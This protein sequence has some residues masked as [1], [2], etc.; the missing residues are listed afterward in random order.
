MK[1]LFGSLAMSATLASN[2]LAHAASKDEAAIKTIV[3]S[4]AVL[5]DRHEF[6]AL[7]T[8]YA[9]ELVLDYSSLSGAPAELKSPQALM[10]EW[11]GVLPGFDRTR[12]ALSDVDATIDGDQAAAIAYVEAGHWIND[13]YWQVD[14][15]YDYELERQAGAWKITSMTFTLETEIGSRDVFGPAMEAAAANPAPYIQRH[16]TRQAVIDFLSGL[17]DKDMETVNG[18][19][20]ED[21]VQ[22]MPYVPNGW[23]HQIIGKQGLIAQYAGWPDVSGA[24]NFTDELIFYPMVDPQTVYVEFKG[25]VDIVSTGRNYRQTYGALF[26][27]DK[28]VITLYREYFDPREFERAFGMSD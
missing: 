23:D 6:E 17:E 24:A 22:D 26:H 12:H 15:R 20:A 14:G 19:W 25:D 11:A 8:L 28:G 2:P 27:V 10:T 4:V 16:Q 5:A 21:A 3:E 1:Q 9:D 18:V 7:E 13:A